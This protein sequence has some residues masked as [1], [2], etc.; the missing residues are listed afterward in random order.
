MVDVIPNAAEN[1]VVGQHVK[2][3]YPL[4]GARPVRSHPTGRRRLMSTSPVTVSVA[5]FVT[6]AT[7][8]RADGPDAERNRLLVE[9]ARAGD[10]DAFGDLVT[11]HE[12]VAFRTALAALGSHE[13]AEEAAQEAF[14]VAW[15]K[16]GGF[17]AEASFRT[18][19]LTIVWR[20]ALDR[21]RRQRAWWSRTA[22]RAPGAADPVDR[23]EA[24]TASPERQALTNDL[25]RKARAEILRLSPRLRDTLLLCASGEH[26]YEQAAALLGV[27]VGTVKWRVSEARRILANRLPAGS[28][29]STRRGDA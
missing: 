25:V 27:P 15:R 26:S 21:R 9:R 8:E 20:K 3:V 1:L 16:L 5:P 23:L 18:W 13:E 22:D 2:S 6:L 10:R 12:R 11:L 14:V 17:R 7:P 24:A 19:L 4:A 28:V 29:R